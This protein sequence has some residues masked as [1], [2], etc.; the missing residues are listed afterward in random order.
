MT[1]PMKLAHIVFR[2][3]DLPAMQQ[4]Y[5][6]VLDAH[7]VFGNDRIAF[8]TYDK[9]HHRIALVAAGPFAARPKEPAVGFY[10]AA[11]AYRD[12]RELLDNHDRLLALGIKPWRVI[13]HGLTISCYYADPDGNDIE[14]QVDRFEDAEDAKIWMTGDAF[15]NNP[16]GLEVDPDALR[17]RLDAGEPIE[18]IMRRADEVQ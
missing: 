2:T 11:F 10:H 8:L 15:A 3:N 4:W 17:R 13:N 9:E 16:V 6:T 18:S 5:C 12:L 14:F 7:V 1:A